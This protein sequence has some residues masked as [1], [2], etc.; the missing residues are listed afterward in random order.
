MDSNVISAVSKTSPSSFFP[1]LRNL[2]LVSFALLIGA[3]VFRQPP[4]V[5][6]LGGVAPLIWYH[7]VYLAPRAR[8]GIS[9][10]AIDSVYYFGFLITIAALGVSAVS[11]ALSGGMEAMDT[12]AYQFGLGLLATGYAIFARMHLTSIS[13][14]LEE[15]SPEGVL[16]R[17]L[18]RTQELVTNVEMA[19]VQFENL[20]SN[21]IARAEAS[22]KHSA[23]TAEKTMLEIARLFDE[24]LRATLSSGN[25]GIADLRALVNET[26]FVEERESLAKNIQVTLECVIQLNKALQEL[27]VRSEE[28]ARSTDE[29]RVRSTTLANSIGQVSERIESLAGDNG[30]LLISLNAF[31]RVQSQASRATV[32]LNEVVDELLQVGDALGSVGPTFK[33]LKTLTSKV[34]LQLEGLSNSSAQLDQA[35]EHF[36]HSSNRTQSFADSIESL[37]ATLPQLDETLSALNSRL[38]KLSSTTNLLEQNLLTL[39]QPADDAITRT[40][41]LREAIHLL[42]KELV[43][44]GAEAKS[45]AGISANSVQTLEKANKFAGE[46]S[47][48]QA[49]TKAVND[50]LD[51]VVETASR[52]TSS[53]AASTEQMQRTVTAASEVLE[54]DVQTSSRAASLFTQR[55]TDVA[56]NI[57]DETKKVRAG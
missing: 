40:S 23:E 51:S 12:I 13:T 3:T 1:T 35:T 14:W 36:V 5:A 32:A 11:L 55:L 52:A 34:Q 54:R 49:T 39:P 9:Q 17:Y 38:E 26:S 50:L 8:S 20:T 43:N 44:A 15:Q 45:L 53:L 29:V 41:D 47:N 25:K 27:T 2:A 22:T 18:M 16:D 42:H 33:N 30:T 48:L 19:S 4:W 24:Q 21:L 28:S 56:Q 57:I 37:A 6:T 31:D 10:A 46:A 7:I